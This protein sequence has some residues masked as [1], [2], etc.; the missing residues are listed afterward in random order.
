MEKLPYWSLQADR[1]FGGFHS[2]AKGLSQSDTQEILRRTGPN[3]IRSRERVISLGLF[4]NQFKSPIVLILIFAT[5]VS[6]VKLQLVLP[7]IWRTN[8]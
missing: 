7:E 5:I 1:L 3:Q 4:L 8:T 6:A 2:S